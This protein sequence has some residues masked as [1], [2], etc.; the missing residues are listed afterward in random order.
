MSRERPNIV[1]I[2]ADGWRGD[3]LGIAGHPDVRTPNIDALALSG[4]V[5]RRAYSPTPT[6]VPARRT[7][8]SGQTAFTHGVIGAADRVPWEFEHTLP[9]ELKAAGYQTHAVGLMHFTP[10]RAR[11][12]FDSIVLHEATR[13]TTPDYVDDYYDWLRQF[14]HVDDRLI[15]VD[16]NSWIARPTHL[17]EWQHP[18]TWTVTEAIKFLSRRDPQCP[19]FLWVS[20]HRP[21]APFDPPEAYFDMY[22]D[23]DLRPPAIGD[24][25]RP[26]PQGI[27][28][29]NAWRA[30]LPPDEM[31]RTQAGYYGLLTHI[32]H[33]VGRLVQAL[34]SCGLLSDTAI[35][36]T[37]DH[38]DMLGDHYLLRKSYA[39]EGSAHIPWVLRLPNG[40]Q[41]IRRSVD[42]V[43]ALQ[44][45]M[46][47]LL[48]IAGVP[49]PETV[50]GM[51]VL[52][53]LEGEPAWRE[54]VHGEHAACYAA[55]NA[56][57][58]LTDGLEK[59]IWFPPTG[60]EQLF[61]LAKDPR[62]CHNLAAEPEHESRVAHW[63]GKLVALLERRSD[64][65]TA[66]GRLV[67]QPWDRP[68]VPR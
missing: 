34:R 59:Y 61:D 13:R 4:A 31:R 5:F 44:D 17:P 66:G 1:L 68:I 45:V 48:D 52:P 51:S 18:T 65:L 56:M 21:H 50:E 3:A 58:Y 28:D 12:G 7:I 16:S 20:F 38:G 29:P 47:T 35:M 55:E 26:A 22:V 63:R 9:G 2:T 15:G 11:L 24:W 54:F 6:C 36:F 23:Q 62:E 10:Q 43:V 57:Q 42:Q 46:P 53:L 40:R 8:M 37:A 25:A 39:Y 19:F 14:T 33:Q 60:E 32:D 27:P 67:P 30:A 64:P 41:P 49:V